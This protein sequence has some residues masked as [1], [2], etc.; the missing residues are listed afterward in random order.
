VQSIIDSMKEMERLNREQKWL[1]K[2]YKRGM[3]R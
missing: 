1:Q 3:S 2:N